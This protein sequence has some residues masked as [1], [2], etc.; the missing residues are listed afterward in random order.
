MAAG[1]KLFTCLKCRRTYLGHDPIPACPQCG[2]DYHEKEAFRWDV[3]AFLFAILGLMSYMLVSAHYRSG[4]A[5]GTAASP[6]SGQSGEHMSEKLPGSGGSVTFSMP[7][8]EG[9]R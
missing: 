7:Y 3:L 1:P 2:Y 8:D 6:S 4:M 9:R 5:L